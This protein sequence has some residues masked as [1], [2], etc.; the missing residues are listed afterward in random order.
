MIK[1]IFKLVWNRKRTNILVVV[2]VFFSFIV[3]FAVVA[4]GVHY[5]RNYTLPLG[6]SFDN[7]WNISLGTLLDD[8]R[9]ND[10]KKQENEEA[11]QVTLA[12]K[13]LPE[14]EAVAGIAMVPFHLGA[15][16]SRISYKGREARL[17]TNDG[18][19]DLA[20]VLRIQIVRGRWF[21]RSDDAANFDAVVINERLR[22]EL[23]GAEDPIGK[24][25]DLPKDAADRKKVKR[26]VGVISDFRQ[27]GEFHEAYNY[28][29]FRKG[30][31]ALAHFTLDKEILVRLRPGTPASFQEKLISKVQS[32]ARSRT[33]QLEP[34]DRARRSHMRMVL[35]PI[36]GAGIVAGFLTLMVGLGMVGVLWQNVSRRTKE[37]GLRR[38]MGGTAGDVRKQILGELL[39]IVTIGMLLGSALLGQVPLLGLVNWMTPDL[40]AASLALSALALYALTVLA[41]LYP[42]WL[43]TRVQPAR[44]LHYE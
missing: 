13:D 27:H 38:A 29:F 32:V 39:V 8:I 40:F 11:R 4:H 3:L 20:R 12:L 30:G 21:D 2:E 23:F 33:V 1:H 19:D 28:A 26:V 14:V 24:A 37:I 22:N 34:L 5:S 9:K 36:V 10:D 6:F 41:G 18:T 35:A 25:F 42:S 43:A 17:R 7:V 44:A 16:S 15:S 31:G